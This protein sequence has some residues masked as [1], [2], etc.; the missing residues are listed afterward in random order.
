MELEVPFLFL[1]IIEIHISN[2]QVLVQS[3]K[4]EK[5]IYIKVQYTR[6]CITSN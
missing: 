1:V 4:Y 5:Q 2:T 6:S 3:I